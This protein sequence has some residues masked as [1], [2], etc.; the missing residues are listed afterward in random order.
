MLQR[1]S[2]DTTFRNLFLP[3]IQLTRQ[4]AVLTAR[5]SRGSEAQQVIACFFRRFAWEHDYFG[6]SRDPGKMNV[7]LSRCQASLTI[8]LEYWPQMDNGVLKQIATH[9]W[10]RQYCTGYSWNSL[11]NIA[12]DH[13]SND[14][15]PTQLDEP[16]MDSEDEMDMEEFFRD[17][18]IL[19]QLAEVRENE[20]QQRRKNLPR[21]DDPQEVPG[22]LWTQYAANQVFTW[23]VR[24]T[25]DVTRGHAQTSPR[26]MQDNSK[27]QEKVYNE[28]K[29]LK[30]LKHMNQISVQ[31]AKSIDMCA[32]YTHLSTLYVF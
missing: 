16:S 25:N 9:L 6:Q 8:F 2:V 10:H 18:Q 19:Q 24:T 13:S 30:Q 3:L 20:K 31:S 32:S 11:T 15:L 28:I 23:V 4:V 14:E 27:I 1:F 21:Y 22:E 29:L 26:R 12:E 5:Q 7:M 17:D